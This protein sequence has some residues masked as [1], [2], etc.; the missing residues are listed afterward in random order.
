VLAAIERALSE[1]GREGE[2]LR[3]ELAGLYRLRVGEYRVVYS[4]TDEGYLVL[5]IRH[6]RE[7]Y[8]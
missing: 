8:R 4:R 2:T 5:R 1:Q 6:R 3:G 7:A